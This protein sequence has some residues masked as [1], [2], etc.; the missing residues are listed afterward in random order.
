VQLLNAPAQEQ[1]EPDVR[2][3]VEREVEGIRERGERDLLSAGQYERVVDVAGRPE[4]GS[5][6]EQQP[7]G[8]L[9]ARDETASR[10][11]DRGHDEQHVVEDRAVVPGTRLDSAGERLRDVHAEEREQ[12][13]TEQQSA[14]RLHVFGACGR[15]GPHV[16]IWP[17]KLPGG[18]RS[19]SPKY[20]AS[21]AGAS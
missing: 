15:Q 9:H 5:Q 11:A 7:G 16:V 18:R 6:A 12:A 3:G 1:G 13:E 8:A 20:R 2:E 4:P 10:A 19:P 17:Q 14:A 21:R